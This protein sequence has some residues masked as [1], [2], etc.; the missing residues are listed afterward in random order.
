[1]VHFPTKKLVVLDWG[2]IRGMPT[3]DLARPLSKK[4]EY[5]MLDTVFTELAGVTDGTRHAQCKRL[6]QFV[7]VNAD[8][9]YMGRYWN[10]ISQQE[11]WNS[12]S[13]IMD[14]VHLELSDTLREFAFDKERTWLDGMIHTSKAPLGHESLRSEFLSLAQD[15]TEWV[16]KKDPDELRSLKGNLDGQID[17]IRRPDQV[18]EF[19][20]E[21]NTRM[22]GADWRA[23]LTSFPDRLAVARFARLIVWYSL[24]QSVDI[25]TGKTKKFEN[26]YD[27]ANYAFASSYSGLIATDDKGLWKAVQAVFPYVRRWNRTEPS[28]VL[29]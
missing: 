2:W 20:I 12:S 10:E 7:Q 8:N 14:L 5:M 16:K 15:W 29:E 23:A 9:L 27:D 6:R 22:Q 19:V 28:A 11:R 1:M 17:W 13:T 25:G 4:F 21:R 3:V 18:A 26:N 24:M